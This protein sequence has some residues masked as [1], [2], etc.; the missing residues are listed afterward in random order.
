VHTVAEN[1]P[2]TIPLSQNVLDL[3]RD[4][5]QRTSSGITRSV[6]ADNTKKLLT[7][8]RVQVG[9]IQALLD[10]GGAAASSRQLTDDARNFL[11]QQ[12]VAQADIDQA[13]AVVEQMQTGQP[14]LPEQLAQ[15]Q[16]D[17][18]AAA[19]FLIIYRP[20]V[21]D[22]VVTPSPTISASTGTG[23]RPLP[24][25]PWNPWGNRQGRR[26]N[27]L[28]I[29]PAAAAANGLGWILNTTSP[30]PHTNKDV[31]PQDGSGD[32]ATQAAVCL[33]DRR[34]QGRD[35]QVDPTGWR[36]AAEAVANINRATPPPN[37]PLPAYPIARLLRT[38]LRT[39]RNRPPQ[40]DGALL[41]AGEQATVDPYL[42]RDG[43]RRPRRAATTR[44]APDRRLPSRALPGISRTGNRVPRPV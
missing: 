9:G 29:R 2:A 39:A 3:L 14:A 31:R 15:Y 42:Y 28:T 36:D 25:P 33:T 20:L 5:H 26:V 40:P 18:A 1:Q 23:T 35:P 32:R 8:Y 4:A 11:I 37:P 21:K 17:I 27:C 24:G 38:I 7:Q 41:T 30:V 16:S 6:A 13:M 34:G 19:T 22:V 44:R 43:H 10:Q 12:G